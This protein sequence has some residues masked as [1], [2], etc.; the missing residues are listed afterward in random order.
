MVVMRL[1]VLLVMVYSVEVFLMR[2]RILLLVGNRWLL[3][4]VRIM[5]GYLLFVLMILRMRIIR[6]NVSR[7]MVLLALLLMVMM[8]NLREMFLL[9]LLIVFVVVMVFLL[10]NV[11]FIGVMVILLLI[12]R[13]IAFRRRLRSGNLIMI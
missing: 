5:C 4:R 13:S 3:M 8:L 11:R 2:L 1:R 7:D 12:C 6:W 9:S 10:R